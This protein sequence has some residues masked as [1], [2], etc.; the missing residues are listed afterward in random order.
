[1]SAFY[2]CFFS[3]SLSLDCLRCQCPAPPPLRERY[4]SCSTTVRC[5]CSAQEPNDFELG[6]SVRTER[7]SCRVVLTRERERHL[8]INEA[9]RSGDNRFLVASINEVERKTPSKCSSS[10]RTTRYYR[11][12]A[13][14]NYLVIISQHACIYTHTRASPYEHLNTSPVIATRVYLYIPS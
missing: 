4:K 13:L 8:S 7:A 5:R 12:R 1:M 14:L 10:S 2:T 6:L 11:H 3:L 9:A